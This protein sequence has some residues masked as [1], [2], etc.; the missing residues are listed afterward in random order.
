M[1]SPHYAD[2]VARIPEAEID[3]D[4]DLVRRLL[5]R[6]HPDLAA[7]PMTIAANG[8]DNVMVRLGDDLAVRI[9]RRAVAARLVEHEQQVLPRLAS[10]LPLD[11]PVP[12]RVGR[13]TPFYPWAWSVVPWRDGAAAAYSPAHERDAWAEQLADVLAALHVPADADAPA[14]PVRGVPLAGRVDAIRARMTGFARAGELRAAF[15]RDAAAPAYT[16]TPLWIHGDPHPLNML[17]RDGA[18]TALIDFGDVTAG[19]PATDLAAAWMTFTARGRAAFIDRYTTM[20]RTG[21]GADAATWLRARAWAAG[22]ASSMLSA[23]D[24]HAALAAIGRHTLAQV[25]DAP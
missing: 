24:D 12:V 10:R 19:D 13:P 18:L 3:V 14:N 20:A 16:G 1:C 21:D 25:L 4:L 6:Q 2:A 8:W 15:D 23:S 11:V 17:C 9:P 5:E 7:L 22:M